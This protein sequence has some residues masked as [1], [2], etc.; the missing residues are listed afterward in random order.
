MLCYGTGALVQEVCFRIYGDR[1]GAAHKAAVCLL[2][3]PAALGGWEPVPRAVGNSDQRKHHRHFHQHADCGCQRHRAVRAKQR[4]GNRDR[5]FKKVGGSNHS[6]RRRDVMRQLERPARK[7]GNLEYQEGL[8]RER[9]GNEH[10][11]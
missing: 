3:L 5:Q 10:N 2:L 9:D 8:Q 7:V 1:A 6:R 4:D 11:V